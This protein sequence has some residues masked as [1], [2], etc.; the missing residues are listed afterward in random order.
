MLSLLVSQ[1][2]NNQ[3]RFGDSVVLVFRNGVIR[4]RFSGQ[5][6]TPTVN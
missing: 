4:V 5:I 1:D 6:V 3:Q 2:H